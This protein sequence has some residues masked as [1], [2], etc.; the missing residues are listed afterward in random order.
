MKWVA[1]FQVGTLL[2]F[3][4]WDSPG[5][6]I[7]LVGIPRVEVFQ[8]RIPIKAWNICKKRV[9]TFVFVSRGVAL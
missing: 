8:G 5:G 4:E 3:F 9:I 2:Q 6:G 7:W 1:L